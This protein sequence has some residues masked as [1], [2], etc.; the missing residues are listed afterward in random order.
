MYEKIGFKTGQ[1]LTA[2]ALDHM[3]D[4]I[5]G[6]FAGVEGNNTKLQTEVAKLE[7]GYVPVEKYGAKGDGVTD[8]SDAIQTAINSLHEGESLVFRKAGGYYKVNKAIGINGKR[9]IR[10]IGGRFDNSDNT[11]QVGFVISG[12]SDNVS[13][14]SCEFYKGQQL[15]M[16]HDC[17]NIYVDRCIFKNS[18]YCVIQQAGYSSNNVNIT[19]NRAIDVYND[20]VALNCEVNAPSENWVV[21]GNIYKRSLDGV[22]TSAIESRFLGATQCANIVISN[23]I[24]EG[25]RGDSA[26][27]VEDTGNNVIISNNVIKN[28]NGIGYIAIM[29][30]RK[31]MIE[32]NMFENTLADVGIP[33]IHATYSDLATSRADVEKI[34][35]RGNSFNGNGTQ[36]NVIHCYGL[37]D[38]ILIDGN[39]FN[40]IDMLFD[41]NQIRYI[42]F[43]NNSVRCNQFIRN[44]ERS[45]T[46]SSFIY[47]AFFA[48][49][50]IYGKVDITNNLNGTTC[51]RLK[52]SN[53][54]FFADVN[55]KNAEDCVFNDNIFAAEKTLTFDDKAYYSKR[56]YAYGNFCNGIGR[57]ADIPAV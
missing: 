15:I 31:I 56:M 42:H 40:D 2:E 52:F 25:A 38:N 22:A 14:E 8:D 34:V 26:I 43:V 51:K 11:S 18:G 23:N 4:G 19:N 57:L 48:N 47:D 7:Q 49:N 39:V 29:T 41:S 50:K 21:T 54:L 3:E 5:S 27:H 16:L 6:A 30:S 32:G 37:N 46:P 36:S 45:A 24:I 33:F 13:F 44:I 17:S 35:I 12:G 10:I 20:F 28:C 1:V 53:N 55:I 9:N